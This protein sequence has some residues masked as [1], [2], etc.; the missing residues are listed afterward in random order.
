MKKKR[1]FTKCPVCDV[2]VNTNNLA[3]HLQ[4]VHNKS[5][6]GEAVRE[7]AEANPLLKMDTGN[8]WILNIRGKRENKEG[9]GIFSGIEG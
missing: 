9:P 3:E 8:G 2:S 7:R 6:D 4:R 1:K 5:I